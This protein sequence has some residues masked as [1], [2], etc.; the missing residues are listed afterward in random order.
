MGAN[1]RAPSE[2]PFGRSSNAPLI[3]V[4]GE[5]WRVRTYNSPLTTHHS[6]ARE[7]MIRVQLPY[8]LRTLSHVEG[9]VELQIEEP[10][11]IRSVL[12]ALESK[13]P[14][15]R[16]T[17]RNHGS[18]QRRPWLRFFACQHD[19]SHEPMETPLP[20]AVVKGEE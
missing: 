20:D 3:G 14:V 10:I 13:Y 18:D 2:R 9:E 7:T 4:S 17:I 6:L 15:L 5:W 11:T 12:D 8:H 16:G 1:C 19:M